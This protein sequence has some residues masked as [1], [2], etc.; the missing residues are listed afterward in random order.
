MKMSRCAFA[1]LALVTLVVA[2]V[3]RAAPADCQLTKDSR[4]VDVGLVDAIRPKVFMPLTQDL[5]VTPTTMQ[6]EAKG[7]R[8]F[9]EVGG[10]SGYQP[11]SLATSLKINTDLH[12]KPEGSMIVWVCPLESLGV[13]SLDRHVL[14]KDPRAHQY[15]ILSDAFP[16]NDIKRSVFAWYW[17]SG[18]HPQM[19]A[20]F[21]SGAAGGSAANY[22]ATPYVPVE[23]LPLHEREWYQFAFTWNKPASRFQIYVNGILCGATIYP[24]QSETPHPQ[25]FL[26]N[27]AMVFADLGIYDVELSSG[28]I[29]KS[30]AAST[31]PRNPAITR[32]LMRLFTF[33]PK[34]HVDWQP[35]PTWTPRYERALTNAEDFTGWIQQGCLEEPYLLKERRITPEGLLV[36]TP[37]QV[38]TETRVYFWSPTA[39][40]GDIAVELEFRPEQET[41]L[42]LLVVQATGMQREDFIADH[43][44]RTS[45]SMR[46]IISDRVR[47][48]HWEFFRK[49][50]DVRADLGTHVLVKNPWHH[51]LGM[52]ST[53]PLRIGEWHKLQFVQENA[54]LRTAIDGE[55]VLDVRDDAFNNNGPILNS[56]RIGLRLMYATRMR[57]RNLKVWNR[58]PFSVL[59]QEPMTV[60]SC[61]L[62]TCRSYGPESGLQLASRSV[63]LTR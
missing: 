15:G 31:Y 33:Q 5:T 56:G 38:H 45:G 41:G 6:V 21:K 3:G 11:L 22:G 2:S 14:S 26:G 8:R 42:A 60:A 30:Y 55:W 37:D 59:S 29:A 61:F 20:K 17:R 13:A 39:F 43:P 27:T 7:P 32:E 19:I 10:K 24:F 23:H 51:P 49:A 1:G 28:D 57:F 16:V 58:T 53:P 4:F 62:P 50:V 46:T 44:K 25:L 12:L 9:I 54:R 36:Q 48:Y 40:E 35:D 34:P 52:S 47:N 63:G 18:W